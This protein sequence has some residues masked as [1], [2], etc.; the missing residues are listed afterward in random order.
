MLYEA[1]AGNGGDGG[2]GGYRGDG[3]NG[4]KGGYGGIL[5]G[6]G[7]D[8]GDG[9]YGGNGGNGGDGGD[10]YQSVL[11]MHINP[12][13]N[14]PNNALVT[15]GVIGGFPKAFTESSNSAQE[16]NRGHGQSVMNR[17]LPIYDFPI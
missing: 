3:G 11:F 7:G 4:G 6:H 16:F 13:Y 17:L 14:A 2:R 8:G 15:N 1:R 12:D 10:A 5:A 9:G